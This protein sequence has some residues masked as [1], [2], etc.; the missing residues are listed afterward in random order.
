M[1]V[2]SLSILILIAALLAACQSASLTPAPQVTLFPTEAVAYP[3]PEMPTVVDTQADWPLTDPSQLSPPTPY[4]PYPGPGDVLG[5]DIIDLSND[6]LVYIR[7]PLGYIPN[8]QFAPLYVAVEKGYYREAGIAIEFDYRFETDGV[9]LVG[10]D[11]LFFAVVSGEQ[12]LLARAQGLPVVYVM[13]WYQDYPVA[14]AAKTEQGIQTP[15]D[16]AGKTVGIPGL[17]GASYIGFRALLSAAGL[18]EADLTLQSIGYN[19]TEALAADQVQAAVVYAANEPVV[20]AARGYAVDVI[21]VS[22]YVTL[23]ANGL[24]TNETTIAQNPDL[25]RRMVQATLRGIA[26]TIANPDEAYEISKAYV[27]GLA[28]ADEAIQKQVL[29][30]SIEFWRADVPGMANLVAWENMQAVLLEMGLLTSPLDL[31][32]AFT[33]VFIEGQ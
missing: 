17:Y 7:L 5:D 32:L 1:K 15:Q 22:D 13:A 8:V 14:V 26:D 33:N 27:E 31:D 24:I 9:A 6:M 30:T 29:A 12:V 2:R 16:L 18:S 20:L 28:E 11:E 23:A 21:R 4:R 19:Q 10:A 3:E 25:V